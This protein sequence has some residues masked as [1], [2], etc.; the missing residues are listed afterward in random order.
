M[1]FIHYTNIMP[2]IVLTLLA[3]CLT[4]CAKEPEIPTTR[5][6]INTEPQ[7]AD[8]VILGQNTGVSPLVIPGQPLGELNIVLKLDGYKRAFH[9]VEIT[10]TTAQ[11]FNFDLVPRTGMV[12]IH[13][14]PSGATVYL[15]DDTLLGKTP[16]EAA[17]VQIGKH[18]LK[19]T[20]EGYHDETEEF[21]VVEDYK[22]NKDITLKAQEGHLKVL[23]RPIGATIWLN[24]QPQ[25]QVTPARFTMKPGTYLVSVYTDGYIQKEQLVE[26][27]ANGEEEVMIK[28]TEGNVP[29]GMVLVPAGEFIRGS[30]GRSPDESPQATLKIPGFYMDKYEVT[31]KEFQNQ[32][33][34]HSFPEGQDMLPVSGVTWAEANDYARAVNKRLP[35]EAEWEKAARGTDGR[36]FP[37][38]MD[39]V[40][41]MCHSE[42]TNARGARSVGTYFRGASPYGCMDMAGNVYEWTSDIYAPYEGN[43][44]VNVDYGQIYRVLRGG[45]FRTPK[46]EVRCATRHFDKINTGRRDYGFR[47]ALD[48]K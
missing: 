21:D 11:E 24:N 45:S 32:F 40:D 1:R 13:S 36:E 8:V 31:N 17:S 15:D 28:M 44:A 37:W 26:I 33:P 30:S 34:N 2:C 5:I 47:C 18:S 39:W 25:K 9:T 7:G 46:F 19:V 27:P 38:G 22:H 43:K 42:E 41:E 16:I 20:L 10:E 35:T 3:L 23:S 6:M 48:I 14:S 12:T 4:H 29:I